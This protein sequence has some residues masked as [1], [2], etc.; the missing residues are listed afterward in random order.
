MRF[1]TRYAQAIGGAVKTGLSIGVGALLPVLHAMGNPLAC[2][3]I[4]L[5]CGLTIGVLIKP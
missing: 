3:T 2:E 5:S 4:T 1:S